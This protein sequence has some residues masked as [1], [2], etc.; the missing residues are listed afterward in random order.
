MVEKGS[1][2]VLKKKR[3]Y[4]TEMEGNDILRI[5]NSALTRHDD[6]KT[7]VFGHVK[8]I[9]KCRVY[10]QNKATRLFPNF[11]SSIKLPAN[12]N[13]GLRNFKSK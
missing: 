5:G 6:A 13:S 3:A 8:F 11:N 12:N 9:P 2:L 1:N 4:C 7:L 10:F